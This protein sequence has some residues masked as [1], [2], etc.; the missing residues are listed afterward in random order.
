MCSQL[1]AFVWNITWKS[2][3]I[4]SLSICLNEQFRILFP[5]FEKEIMI[6]HLT[7]I[8]IHDNQE[9]DD[10]REFRTNYELKHTKGSEVDSGS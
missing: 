7:S 2:L 4:L 10:T 5:L 1:G 9:A 8:Q 3:I 6:T